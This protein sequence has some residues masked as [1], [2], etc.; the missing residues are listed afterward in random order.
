MLKCLSVSMFLFLFFLTN[1]SQ[2]PFIKGG[3]RPSL[4]KDGNPAGRQAEMGLSTKI[5]FN[6]ILFFLD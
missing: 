3:T 1:P 6:Y 2:P 4:R 5:R